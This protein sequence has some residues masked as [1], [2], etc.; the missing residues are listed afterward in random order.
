MPTS[1][2]LLTFNNWDWAKTLKNSFT[3]VVLRPLHKK[4][5]AKSISNKSDN[6]LKNVSDNTLK[7]RNWMTKHSRK[8]S[9][10]AQKNWAQQ[11]KN[12][13]QE[14]HEGSSWE[15]KEKLD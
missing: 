3:L 9:T 15:N 13:L 14:D 6:T 2:E 5:V 4:W 11:L 7:I 10:T 1:P 12:R 8:V